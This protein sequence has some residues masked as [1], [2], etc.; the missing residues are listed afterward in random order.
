MPFRIPWLNEAVHHLLEHLRTAESTYPGAKLKLTYSLV[1][2]DST[3]E[4]GAQHFPRK[5]E[6]EASRRTIASPKLR[7]QQNTPCL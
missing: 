5:S 4:I 2:I 6:L 1:G 3:A 7:G